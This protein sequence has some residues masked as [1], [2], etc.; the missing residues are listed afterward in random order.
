MKKNIYVLTFFVLSFG[1]KVC[2]QNIEVSWSK[3]QKYSNMYMLERKSS[4][5]FTC[6]FYEGN[7][8]RLCRFNGDHIER[9]VPITFTS[10]DGKKCDF[11]YIGMLG[12]K[13]AVIYS[14]KADQK[15]AKCIYLRFIDTEN[16]HVGEERILE[17][18]PSLKEG[19]ITNLEY[20]IRGV[21]L[22]IL[23]TIPF[24]K[25]EHVLFGI[26]VY[27][28]NAEKINN[29]DFVLED[30]LMDLSVLHWNVNPKHLVLAVSFT[31]KL[32][33]PSAQDSV[34]YATQVL[35]GDISGGTLSRVSLYAPE[36]K[37]GNLNAVSLLFNQE[38]DLL[39]LTHWG[40][41]FIWFKYSFSSQQLAYALNLPQQS[42]LE[43]YAKTQEANVFINPTNWLYFLNSKLFPDGSVI[44]VAH[45]K[46]IGAES[47]GYKTY[48]R[49]MRHYGGIVCYKYSPNGE[50]QWCKYVSREVRT[51]F[52][53]ISLF[54]PEPVFLVNETVILYNK[55]V[56]NGK[57]VGGKDVNYLGY[58][59]VS[60]DGNLVSGE[61]NMP[62]P[63][64]RIDMSD[65][66]DIFIDP[67]SFF[68][69]LKKEIFFYNNAILTN[70]KDEILFTGS[71]GFALCVGKMKVR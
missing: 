52:T 26:H 19:E 27:G 28:P 33:G 70:E 48:E 20:H 57:V 68:D 16:L 56:F 24:A 8:S 62:K 23:K 30:T 50:L 65:I 14:G 31:K 10:N 39:I 6:L 15:N 25:K 69:N 34:K 41:R 2:A 38:N 59:R 40:F 11:E 17:I 42:L 67:I 53:D 18:I 58:I 45:Q 51:P 12:E 37:I 29:R 64:A 32:M 66:L 13:Y 1:N 46:K 9:E 7:R 61:L 71:D 36:I 4:D 3:P 35:I 47:T 49:N 44:V 54:H 21:N 22:Y 43:E 5:K 60:H 55:A 63:K